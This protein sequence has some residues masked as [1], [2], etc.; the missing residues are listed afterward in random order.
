M[1]KVERRAAFEVVDR[2]EEALCEYTGAPYAVAVD[3]CTNAIFLAL[4]WHREQ[5]KPVRQVVEI[6]KHTYIGV[7]QAALESGCLIEFVDRKW[8]GDYPLIGTPVLDSAKR[9]VRGMYEKYTLTC[10]SF[11]AGKILPIGRG[12]AILTDDSGAADWLRKA[13][14]D[15]RTAGA[16]YSDATFQRPGYH[17]YMTPP[18]AARG[19]WLLTYADDD[20]P[21]DWTEYP[22]LSK[23][24]WV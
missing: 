20:D 4:K 10:L 23:A 24:E 17:M 11:Q 5:I 8:T 22:D 1:E 6:P 19:L 9:F 7:A 18:D 13:R 16:S 14:L 21:G 15:G 12:G 3:S 2:F